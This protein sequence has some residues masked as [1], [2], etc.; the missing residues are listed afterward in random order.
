[1]AYARRGPDSQTTRDGAS[2]PTY[3]L[4]AVLSIVSMYLDQRQGWVDGIRYHLEGIA[5]PVQLLIHAPVQGWESLNEALRSRD[6]L[7]A[8]IADL[9]RRERE[10]SVA[11]LRMETLQRENAQLR[12]LQQTVAPLVSRALVAEV[13]GTEFT[14]LRQRLLV[15]KGA[16]DGVFAGQAALDARGIIGQVTRAG[17]YSAEIILVSDPE[18]A[19]PVQVSRNGLRSIAVGAGHAGELLLPYLPVNSDVKP[20]DT[21]VSSGLGGVFPAGYPVAIVTGI[22]RDPALLLAQVRARPLATLTRDRE[23]MLVWFDPAHPAAPVVDPAE[24]LPQVTLGAP[25]DLV[26]AADA[27]AEAAAQADTQAAAQQQ[28]PQASE[29]TPATPGATP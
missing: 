28:A 13:I 17:P 3:A 15:N 25:A 12:A 2:G 6:S 27:A 19:A 21:L 16:R 10:L 8:E 5:H 18:H 11:T 1:M 29:T 4:F 14:P 26:E 20:G 23:I 7:R 24:G 22:K 9:K